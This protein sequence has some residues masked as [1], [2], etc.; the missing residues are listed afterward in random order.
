MCVVY[1]CKPPQRSSFFLQEIVHC[2]SLSSTLYPPRPELLALE[3]KAA[4]L[5]SMGRGLQPPP[6]ADVVRVE[7]TLR[8][9]LVQTPAMLRPRRVGPR[10]VRF[11]CTKKPSKSTLPRVARAALIV[12]YGVVVHLVV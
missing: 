9:T 11:M 2:R 7:H 12:A 6:S 8:G 4:V 10:P 5:H 3:S 1:L